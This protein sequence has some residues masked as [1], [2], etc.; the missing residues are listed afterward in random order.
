MP[1][2]HD[3]LHSINHWKANVKYQKNHC[4]GCDEKTSPSKQ[5][6]GQRTN[7]KREVYVDLEH[8]SRRR[9]RHPNS[10]IPPKSQIKKNGE[11]HRLGTSLN[12]SGPQQKE[13][14]RLNFTQSLRPHDGE[15]HLNSPRNN[16][17]YSSCS[18]ESSTSLTSSR[19]EALSWTL[20]RKSRFSRIVLRSLR[21]VGK[22]FSRWL[23][24]T[25]QRKRIRT[26]I[27]G[28]MRIWMRMT[29]RTEGSLNL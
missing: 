13:P 6:H 20:T 5:H 12:S 28:L 4:L 26:W 3:W 25:V 29:E 18:K 23:R 8:H 14:L 22:L 21:T 19:K 7:Q 10:Q 2:P 9:R 24:S 11:L 1:F 17:S 27:G 16:S 15:Q